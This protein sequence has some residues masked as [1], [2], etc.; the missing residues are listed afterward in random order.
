MWQRLPL[1]RKSSRDVEEPVGEQSADRA[2]QSA[3]RLVPAP[4]AV[5][6]AAVNAVRCPKSLGLQVDCARDLLRCDL[7]RCDAAAKHI[8][9]G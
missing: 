7:R 3:D 1:K 4:K 2:E 5:L 6:E 9:N 8:V